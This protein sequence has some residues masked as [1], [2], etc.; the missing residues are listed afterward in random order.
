M[1]PTIGTGNRAYQDAPEVRYPVP[2]RRFAKWVGFG[3]LFFL[4]LGCL[5]GGCQTARYNTT[6]KHAVER[7]AGCMVVAV[8]GTRV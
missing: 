5:L 2:F 4:L 8:N 1:N 7:R 6:P 3:F